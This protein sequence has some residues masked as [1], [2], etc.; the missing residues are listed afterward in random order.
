MFGKKNRQKVKEV[1]GVF[2]GL[3]VLWGVLIDLKVEDIC[4]FKRENVVLFLQLIFK[5]KF[6]FILIILKVFLLFVCVCQ[7]FLIN[8]YYF[9]ENYSLGSF[10]L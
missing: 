4:F 10:M 6:L 3:D 7:S 8:Y 9:V 1:L 5:V 2:L